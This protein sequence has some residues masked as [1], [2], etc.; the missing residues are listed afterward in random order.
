MKKTFFK[1]VFKLKVMASFIILVSAT[2]VLHS[3]SEDNLETDTANDATENASLGDQKAL[4]LN[5]NGQFK[6][7]I[8]SVDVIDHKEFKYILV[9][10]ENNIIDAFTDTDAFQ[11]HNGHANIKEQINSIK[12]ETSNTV[13]PFNS[14]EEAEQ[15]IIQDMTNLFGDKIQNPLDTDYSKSEANSLSFIFDH[16]W[17]NHTNSLLAHF[18][19]NSA[20]TSIDYHL[21]AKLKIST[22][23]DSEVGHLHLETTN[24]IY[25]LPNYNLSSFFLNANETT[26]QNT[27]NYRKYLYLYTDSNYN[28][29]LFL[30]IIEKDSDVNIP[31]MNFKSIYIF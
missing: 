31:K 29:T 17:P 12:A 13:F 16:D 27:Y 11:K 3:C 25:N 22:I 15:A 9:D 28:G 26:I 8:T 24:S 10:P 30:Y 23:A 6:E 5:V 7:Y 14:A 20:F 1:H 19:G 21:V 18:E 2:L 4:K